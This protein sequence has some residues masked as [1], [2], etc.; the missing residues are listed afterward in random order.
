VVFERISSYFRFYHSD[1]RIKQ[2]VSFRYRNELKIKLQKRIGF[3]HVDITNPDTRMRQ[4]VDGV[5]NL[6]LNAAGTSGRNMLLDV[7]SS[8]SVPDKDTLSTLKASEFAARLQSGQPGCAAAEATS[9]TGLFAAGADGATAA[10]AA[11]AIPCEE[12]EG[13]EHGGL[14][15]VSATTFAVPAICLISDTNLAMNA[16]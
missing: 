2:Y 4:G 9:W 13:G 5:E 11:A 16:N 8:N 7:S 3:M 12:H 15:S 14:D 1:V 6:L 10:A